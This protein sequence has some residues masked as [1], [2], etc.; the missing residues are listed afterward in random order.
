MIHPIF[1]CFVISSAVYH[2]AVSFVFDMLRDLLSYRHPDLTI[3]YYWLWSYFWVIL[4]DGPLIFGTF[5]GVIAL[6]YYLTREVDLSDSTLYVSINDPFSNF[7]PERTRLR[8]RF[9]ARTNRKF[10]CTLVRF[11]VFG[12]IYNRRRRHD[13]YRYGYSY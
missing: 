1:H 13:C 10:R 2:I 12:R 8:R 5:I 11:I 7:S 3:F 6:K 4:R 9:V